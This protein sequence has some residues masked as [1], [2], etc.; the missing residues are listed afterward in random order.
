MYPAF[1]LLMF[2][3]VLGNSISAATGQASIFGT[4]P[5][6]ILVGA[7]FGSIASAVGLK[8]EQASGL[9]SRF[10]DATRTPRIRSCRTHDC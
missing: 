5:L 10:L 3:V 1:M 9:L 8:G 7:M 6:I 2:R 4:V